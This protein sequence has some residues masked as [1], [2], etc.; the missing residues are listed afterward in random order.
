MESTGRGCPFSLHHKP[1]IGRQKWRQPKLECNKV[2]Y[3]TYL[4]LILR[5]S[6][7]LLLRNYILARIQRKRRASTLD[8]AALDV[9]TDILGTATVHSATHTECCSENFL[10]T[11]LKCLAQ[12]LEPHCSGNFNDLVHGDVAAVFDVLLL[13]AVTGRLLEGADDE[14][15]G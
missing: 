10:D 8:L 6:P 7:Y 13:L 12:T 5:K 11:T 15:R 1:Y 4:S 3:A 9:I 2:D 14:G